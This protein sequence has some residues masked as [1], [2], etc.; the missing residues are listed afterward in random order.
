MTGLN[1]KVENTINKV[2]NKSQ[3]WT[4]LRLGEQKTWWT[5]IPA[6]RIASPTILACRLPT[7]VSGQSRRNPS[8]PSRLAG[9]EAGMLRSFLV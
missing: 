5:L 8:G 9:T 6:S 2:Q 4:H 3:T 1:D 7:T